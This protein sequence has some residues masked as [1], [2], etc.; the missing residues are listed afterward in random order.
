MKGDY[1]NR[2]RFLYHGSSKY[3]KIIL[4]YQAYD[5][6][7]DEGCYEAVYATS[8]KDIALS[9]ALGAVPDEFGKIGRVMDKKYGDDIK[10]I[11]YHGHPNFGDRGFLYKLSSEG[12]V[13]TRGTQWISFQSVIPIEIYEINVDDYLYL[14]RYATEEEK[15]EMEKI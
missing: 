7:Y 1:L 6:A 13:Y 11:F 15:S 8:E 2:P 3:F 10:M 14:F 9:F 12:F 4:P 5:S